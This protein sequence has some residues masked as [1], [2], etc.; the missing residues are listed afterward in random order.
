MAGDTFSF[1]YDSRAYPYGHL[2]V[3]EEALEIGVGPKLT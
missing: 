3:A 1:H 2:G